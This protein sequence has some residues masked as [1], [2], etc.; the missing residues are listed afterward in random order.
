MS[1]VQITVNPIVTAQDRR[2]QELYEQEE[3]DAILQQNLCQCAVW[4]VCIA[5]VGSI[6][7]VILYTKH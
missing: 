1:S 3:R 2:L 6:L 7:M 4:I 5:I